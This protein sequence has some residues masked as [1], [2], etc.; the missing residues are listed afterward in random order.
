MPQEENNPNQKAGQDVSFLG[1]AK[2]PSFGGVEMAAFM[3]DWNG[4][5]RRVAISIEDPL[6]DEWGYNVQRHEEM[7]PLSEVLQLIGENYFKE[8]LAFREEPHG[9]MF[10]RKDFL[11]A[12]GNLIPLARV[13][14]DLKANRLVLHKIHG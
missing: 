4:Q 5:Q 14:E 2:K 6:L 3:I 7:P 1:L 12:D 8:M 9:Y 13:L 10:S 11:D